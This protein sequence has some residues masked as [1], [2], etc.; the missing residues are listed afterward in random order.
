MRLR[1]EE[2]PAILVCEGECKRPMLHTFK[3]KTIHQD[4]FGYPSGTDVFYSCDGCGHVRVWGHET[5]KQG[6]LIR[7]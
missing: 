6:N 5:F 4:R 3:E 1:Q 2:E 7:L